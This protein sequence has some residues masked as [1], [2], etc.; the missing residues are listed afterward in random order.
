MSSNGGNC[1]GLLPSDAPLII[2]S[3]T[4]GYSG[5]PG[6][7]EDEV[8]SAVGRRVRER[9]ER[10]AKEMGCGIRMCILIMRMWSRMFL[11]GMGRRIGRG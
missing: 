10:V 1:L 3:F 9:W 7:R 6:G 2:S 4:I 5:T 8:V 11:L